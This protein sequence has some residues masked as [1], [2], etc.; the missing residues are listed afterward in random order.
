MHDLPPYLIESFK[1]T[2]RELEFAAL[3]LHVIDCASSS[4]FAQIKAVR[5]IL[6]ELALQDKPQLMVFN[7]IDLL[8]G[9]QRVEAL[10]EQFPGAV[11]I[12]ALKKENMG[13]LS[14]RLEQLLFTRTL[15]VRVSLDVKDS[16][17]FHVL[18]DMGEVKN[19]VYEQD[20]AIFSILVE[21]TAL[22]RIKK[23]LGRTA[24]SI[25]YGYHNM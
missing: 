22:E 23:I 15:E 5:T 10:R 1:T 13:A 20:K 3:L 17:Q 18:Y 9:P 4:C 6:E 16:G 8:E 12:S 25:E 7:K 2:L 11:F 21:E 19:V 14:E 24:H